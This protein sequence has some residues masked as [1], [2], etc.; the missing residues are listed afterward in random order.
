[1]VGDSNAALFTFLQHMQER[2]ELRE[3]DHGTKCL[4]GNSVQDWWRSTRYQSLLHLACPSLMEEDVWSILSSYGV[5]IWDPILNPDANLVYMAMDTTARKQYSTLKEALYQHY[6]I[7]QETYRAKMVQ[8]RR[9]AG[10]SW[11]TCG[12]G[13]KWVKDCSTLG[14]MVDVMML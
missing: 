8:V 13:W 5:S 4:R 9:K 14:D 3:R 10:E 2:I 11:T 12:Q 7:S 1:M 6:R